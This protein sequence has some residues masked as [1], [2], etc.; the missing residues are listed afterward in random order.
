MN[1]VPENQE[2]EKLKKSFQDKF[3]KELAD[4]PLM[5]ELLDKMEDDYNT[6]RVLKKQLEEDLSLI[7]ILES[8]ISGKVYTL[9]GERKAPSTWDE[10]LRISEDSIKQFSNQVTDK[11]I[12]LARL[13]VDPSDY[14]TEPSSVIY[15]QEKLEELIEKLEEIDSK[16]DEESHNLT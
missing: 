3:N 14:Q 2:I 5:L 6:G 12:E 13:N 10:V 15:S 1:N 7:E 9:L 16:I 11:M 8:S 4:M